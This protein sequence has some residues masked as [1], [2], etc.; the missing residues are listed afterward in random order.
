[1]KLSA[2][3]GDESLGFVAD[4]LSRDFELRETHI[5]WVFLGTDAVF[6]IKKPVSLDFLDF[7]TLE[8]RRQACEAEVRLNQR[9]TTGVYL[10]VVPVTRD[11]DG[12]HQFDGDG[13]VVEWAVRMR[14]L[15]DADR[16]DHRLKDGTLT[17]SDLGAVAVTLATFH[18]A[19]RVDAAT[20]KFGTVNAIERNVR[21]N[22]EQTRS[23]IG[24]W[25]S[26]EEAREIESTQ[27]AFL[28]THS[29]LFE[30]RC[31]AGH[32][33]DGHGDLRLEHI[34]FDQPTGEIQILDCIEF[35]ER[36]R[37]ADVCADIAFLAMDLAW[38]GHPELSENFLAAYARATNDYDL[39]AL[40]DFYESYRAY[41]R[42]KVATIVL[43]NPQVPLPARQ[44]LQHEARRYFMLALAAE[45]RP[46]VPP[47]VI[48]VGGMIGAG[49]STFADAL[50][51]Q[52]AC[53][54]VDADRTRKHLLG[55]EPTQRL[56]DAAFS[57][58]YSPEVTDRVYAEV[59]RRAS[60][61]VASG[62]SV[63]LDASFRT[64]ALRAKA[65]G[66]ADQLGVPFLFAEC[67][68]PA[69]VCRERL[70]RRARGESVSDGRVE[71][72]EDFAARYQPI[73]EADSFDHWSI[74]T[75]GSAEAAVAEWL[76]MTGEIAL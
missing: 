29:H 73:C 28:E 4:F 74:D 34:Y 76:R 41:V 9:L 15:S 27:L 64:V 6:K 3:N 5:S 45:R 16:A 71:I 2:K 65:K 22:F 47:Q 49:K 51:M 31:R 35:N 48:A 72:F 8:K 59:L 54:V 23:A 75:R 26:E 57:D 70:V 55:A 30:A 11:A 24:Q 7:G 56:H 50:A 39:Y 1:M 25:L 21:E 38:H 12:R 13:D 40:V 44:R 69:S 33:R 14:R 67:V 62:R 43:A 46:L 10:G 36:F 66:L 42:G 20:M 53:P 61:V 19:A 63:I 60:V 17:S 68:A 58:A 52:L 37:Y 18:Q 32:V